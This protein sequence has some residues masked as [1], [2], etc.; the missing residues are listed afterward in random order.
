MKL[1]DVTKPETRRTK[2][3]YVCYA[4]NRIS[5]Q[6]PISIYIDLYSGDGRS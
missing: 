6:L 2:T 5:P 3:N 1:K 4:M